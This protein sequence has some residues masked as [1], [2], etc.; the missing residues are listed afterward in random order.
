[1][2]YNNK[3]YENKGGPKSGNRNNNGNKKFTP[4]K[5]VSIELPFVVS[6]VTS[7]GDEFN[8]DSASE[9]V[10]EMTKAGF[11]DKQTVMA[12]CAKSIL[13]GEGAKGS[14][15]LAR[16]MGL[17]VESGMASLLFFGRGVEY[18]ELMEDMAVVPRV[19]FDRESGDVTCISSF[20]VVPLAEA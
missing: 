13:H 10:G 5:P 11:Y 7:R 17:N 15:E 12:K 3:K 18:S 8:A 4:T 20:E 6:G 2:A 19:R 14:A 1:M 9:L 16:F